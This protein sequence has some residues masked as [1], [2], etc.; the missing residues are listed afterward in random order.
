MTNDDATRAMNAAL[1]YARHGLGETRPNPSVGALVMRDGVVLGRGR[2]SKGGRPHAERVALEAAG[3]AARGATLIVTLEPCARRSQRVDAISCTDAIIEAGIARVVIGADD[4]SGFANGEGAARMRTA[5]IEVIT[6][7]SSAAAR[8]LNL[9]HILRVQEHRPMVSLKLAQTAD[10]FAGTQSGGPIMITGPISFRH[11]HLA[12]AE[13][14]AI[15]V[16]AGTVLGDDPQ[17]NCRLPGL[18]ARSPER[19]VLDGRLRTPLTAKVVT[20]AGAIPTRIFTQEGHDPARLATFRA[21]GVDITELPV[22]EGAAAALRAVLAALA[23]SGVTRLMVEGG[24]TL[25]EA[26]ADADLID[27]FTLMTG[28]KAVG[29]GVIALRPGLRRWLER[30]DVA[31]TDADAWGE[32][33]VAF[34]ERAR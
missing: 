32:D 7:V 27:D 9:G 24:P 3:P 33:R 4:P 23:A 29:A 16:G 25:A 28:P 31:A 26:L 22:E 6:G 18:E 5:G 34:Y 11:T 15:M 20:T 8:K 21:G 19:I 30:A 13:A 17:L 1:A 14:D 2:T 12:R 10:G